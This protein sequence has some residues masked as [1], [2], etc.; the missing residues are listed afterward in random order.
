MSWFYLEI[1]VCV[2]VLEF[3]YWS[4][5]YVLQYAGNLVFYFTLIQMNI[6][7]SLM[8]Y[9]TYRC[10]WYILNFYEQGRVSKSCVVWEYLNCC[11]PNYLVMFPSYDWLCCWRE[12]W[13]CF[14]FW[15]P[16]FMQLE[17]TTGLLFFSGNTWT[18]FCNGNCVFP[19]EIKSSKIGREFHL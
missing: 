17:A 2:C 14:L 15:L 6:K 5:L 12:V 16:S 11:L 19:P 7:T 1:S 3:V 18:C 8:Y 9:Y 10:Q 4:I 13:R